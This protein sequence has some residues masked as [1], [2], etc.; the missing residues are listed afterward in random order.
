[1]SEISFADVDPLDC[2]QDKFLASGSEH[3]GDLR[4]PERWLILVSLDL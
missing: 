1:M 4:L 3:C 2:A